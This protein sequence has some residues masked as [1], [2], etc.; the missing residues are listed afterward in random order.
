MIN[1]DKILLIEWVDSYKVND[2]Q[3]EDDCKVCVAL[4]RSVGFFVDEDKDGICLA[5]SK[6]IKKGYC[7]YGDLIS[8]PKVAIKK[9][10]RINL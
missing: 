4:I 9:I 2:W 5:L 3:A 8:I 10:K 7:P 1:K 6:S